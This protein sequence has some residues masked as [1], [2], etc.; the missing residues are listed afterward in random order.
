MAQ[1]TPRE[2]IWRALAAGVGAQVLGSVLVT[3]DSSALVALAAALIGLGLIAVFVGA[4]AV[5]VSLGLADRDHRKPPERPPH[6]LSR[7]NEPR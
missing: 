2:S 6:P 4:V 5:G 7:L 3:S 1:P